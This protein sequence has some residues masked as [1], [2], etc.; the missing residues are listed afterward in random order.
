[1]L[2][3]ISLGQ[4]ILNQAAELSYIAL[5][6][7]PNNLTKQ[8]QQLFNQQTQQH[9]IF[10]QQDDGE[11]LTSLTRSFHLNLTAMSL[12]AFIVGLFIA[13]NGVRYSLL[14]RQ[15]LLV[16]LQQQGVP[17]RSLLLALLFELLILVLVGSLVGFILGLQLSHWLQPM[18]ALTLE[19]LYGARLMPGV[20]QW[21]WLYQAIGLTFFAALLACYPLFKTLAK[22]P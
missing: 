13:Y 17:Q 4:K 18:I 12:L 2:L 9:F 14:K 21:S 19:Q 16:Q 15:K 7:N 11:G 3:D 20:W 8:I 10:T 6:D 1:I 22:Q 5:F